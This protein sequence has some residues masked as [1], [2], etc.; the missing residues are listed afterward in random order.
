MR[1]LQGTHA[2]DACYSVTING[3][4]FSPCFQAVVVH[5]YLISGDSALHNVTALIFVMFEVGQ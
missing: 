3:M 2:H 1:Y 4:M 5:L